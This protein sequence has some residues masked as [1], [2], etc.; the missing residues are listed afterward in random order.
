MNYTDLEVQNGMEAVLEWHAYVR[1]EIP[2]EKR[3]AVRQ[4]LL[5]YCKLDTLAMVRIWG[6]LMKL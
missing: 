6:E 1:E 5:G 3:T 2:L 4:A